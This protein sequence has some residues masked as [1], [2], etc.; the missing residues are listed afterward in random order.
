[1]SVFDK[2]FYVVKFL[3]SNFH[4]SAH[5]FHEKFI[6]LS[7]VTE[8]CKRPSWAFCIATMTELCDW[9]NSFQ[10]YNMLISGVGGCVAGFSAYP[11]RFD[12]VKILAT[13]VKISKNLANICDYL[14]KI[15]EIL[16]KLPEN[17]SKLVSNVVWFE[18]Y[19]AQ[20]VQN[21]IKTPFLKIIPKMIFMRNVCA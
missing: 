10:I 7:S 19:G 1:M 14:S 13:P 17:T 18:E 4:I 9:G 6:H 5:S 11:K 2:F 16:G 15:L 8:H 3:L 20:C 21:H 12:L